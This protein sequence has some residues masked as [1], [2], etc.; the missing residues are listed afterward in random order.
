[1]AYGDPCQLY[2]FFGTGATLPVEVE[3]TADIMFL[4]GRLADAGTGSTAAL[5]SVYL[6]NGGEIVEF[7]VTITEAI[8]NTNSTRNVLKIQY[9]SVY[10]A[11]ATAAAAMT[12]PNATDGVIAGTSSQTIWPDTAT[13]ANANAVGA[14]II[15]KGANIPFTCAPGS[16]FYLE[17]TTAAGAAGGAYLPWVIVRHTTCGVVGTSASPVAKA[18]TSA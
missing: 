5:D 11:T 10:G 14:R 7:G 16:N 8:T 12:I 6:P 17:V 4:G 1:M 18:Q 13:L 3:A 9:C 2:Q 15:Y